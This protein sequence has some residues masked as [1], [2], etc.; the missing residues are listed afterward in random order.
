MDAT[1]HYSRPE[2][3]SLMV[4]RTPTA[5]LHERAQQPVDLGEA[6]HDRA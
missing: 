4:D 1:G 6:E 5:H 3:L 2:L